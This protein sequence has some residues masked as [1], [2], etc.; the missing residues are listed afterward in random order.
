M[1]A[2]A[3][4][5]VLLRIACTID[6]EP[7]EPFEIAKGWGHPLVTLGLGDFASEG[8]PGAAKLEFLSRASEREGWA[9]LMLHPGTYYLGVFG[10]DASSSTSA[11][12]LASQGAR[13]RL[14]VPA[15]AVPVYA[16]SLRLA[17]KVDGTLM[18]GDRIIRPLDPAEVEIF[19]E[20]G[21]AAELLAAH[22]SG[23]T[24]V[25]VKLERWQAGDTVI[26]STPPS[27]AKRD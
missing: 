9:F 12:Q 26:L 6:G 27:A 16:G 22:A 1:D 24:P 20:S 15:S 2:P 14:V 8:K 5:L 18:F 7:C 19:D 10:P 25:P 23:A 4:T 11:D 17:G 21:R 3:K 13:W